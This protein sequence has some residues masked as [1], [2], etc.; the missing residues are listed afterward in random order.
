MGGYTLSSLEEITLPA[1]GATPPMPWAID[2][3]TLAHQLGIRNSTLWWA[4]LSKDKL[5]RIYRVPKRT[6][7]TGSRQI[8][9]PDGRLKYIQKKLLECFLQP[10]PLGEHVGAYVTGRS[11]V[12]TA[13]QHV[14]KAV[15][16]SLDLKDFFPSIKRS[17]IRRYLK[18]LGYSHKVASLMTALMTYKNFAPQ[19]APTSGTIAN[20]VADKLL[21]Q[22]VLEKLRGNDWVYTRYSDDIDISS[23]KEQS[24]EEIKR[25]IKIVTRA[26]QRAGFTVKDAKTKVMHHEKRQKV[27]GLIV[28]DKVSIDPHKFKYLSKLIH[29]CK[30]KGFESQVPQTIPTTACAIKNLCTYIAGTLAYFHQVEPERTVKLRKDFELAIQNSTSF[31]HNSQSR[32]DGGVPPP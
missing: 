17:M 22:P 20:L 1:S 3:M 29:A 25:I 24:D 27:L 18:D 9:E 10:L 7:G 19:G 31:V 5:Y 13:R 32:S 11:I 21:D 12:H 15:I 4:V 2:D 30:T 14:K 16:V 26:A 23:V 6:P 28:N 8:Q